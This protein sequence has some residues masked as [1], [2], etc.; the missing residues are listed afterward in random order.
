MAL[1]LI[2]IFATG[3]ITADS[4]AQGARGLPDPISSTELDAMLAVAGADE[5]ERALAVDPH[6][7]YLLSMATFREGEIESWLEEKRQRP[8]MPGSSDP[9]TMRRQTAERRHLAMRIAALDR[10][11]FAELS[12]SGIN[13]EVIERARSARSRA[14]SRSLA[15]RR[16]TNGIRFE[17]LEVHA[18]VTADPDHTGPPHDRALDAN[19]LAIL[20]EHDRLRT[21]RLAALADAAIELPLIRAQMKAESGDAQPDFRGATVEDMEDWFAN[22]ERIGREAA[23]DARDLQA[24]IVRLDRT[25]LHRI[26]SAFPDS[27]ERAF[28]V[29]FRDA[30][31][32]A[33]HPTGFPDRESPAS[34]F[35]VA[36][37]AREEGELPEEAYAEIE[38]LEQTWR[39]SHRALEDKL[40]EAIEDEIRSGSSRPNLE[41]EGIAI[42]IEAGGSTPR[43]NRPSTGIR[44]ARADLDRSIRTR[45]ETLSPELLANRVREGSVGDVMMGGGDGPG[46]VF[47]A[48]MIGDTMGGEP[49]QI[50]GGA[51]AFAMNFISDGNSGIPRPIDRAAFDTLIMKLNADDATRPICDVLFIAY[52]DGW[53]EIEETLVAAFQEMQ[54]PGFG[55][56]GPIHADPVD[57]RRRA[58]RHGDIFNALDELDASLFRDLGTVIDTPEMIKSSMLQRRREIAIATLQGGRGMFPGPGR[59][60]LADLDLTVAMEKVLPRS[61]WDDRIT[62]LSQEYAAEITPAM[63]SRTLDSIDV[64]RDSQLAEQDMMKAFSEGDDGNG[65]VLRSVA[66]DF[67]DQSDLMRSMQAIDRRRA[68]IESGMVDR[69]SNWRGRLAAA[70]PTGIEPEFQLEVD[71]LAWP[72]CFRDPR[73]PDPLF[74]TALDLPDLTESQHAALLELRSSWSDAWNSTCRE[75]MAIEE[76]G[77]GGANPFN[78]EF[79]MAAM[80]KG[81]SER[82]R[83]RFARSELDE[84]A[85]RQLLDLLT[86][87]Q[88]AAVGELPEPS[89][90]KFPI[91][92]GDLE[93]FIGG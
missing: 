67:N 85:M 61:E 36:R 40:V 4:F 62:Q 66:I 16:F 14:R 49:I 84:R 58:E 22:R 39:S 3:S 77:G 73:S 31:L 44:Q 52:Q 47:S 20:L 10:G 91:E 80:Q 46:M 74:T 83:I 24:N 12:D 60:H 81:Q 75:L 76:R 8:G 70:L 50:D 21:S 35:D 79:D 51:G 78:G 13:P 53:L 28:A 43:S 55:P 1:L 68:A 19:V 71:R 45:L 93:M 88:S 72:K 37:V 69:Q 18:S 23:I 7:R 9:E 32:A 48:V 33:A 87:A 56:A 34:L 86:P 11:L 29:A 38:S 82:K 64:E 54:K 6:S 90:A 15:G 63:V 25:V 27:D 42:P 26:L 30:W 92:F 17:P 89:E 2:A 57:I 59:N 41:I 65:A 5:P